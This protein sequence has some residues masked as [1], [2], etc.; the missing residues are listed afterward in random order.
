VKVEE[1]EVG[2]TYQSKGRDKTT[3][4]VTA[5]EDHN[6]ASLLPEIDG[7]DFLTYQLVRFQRDDG[8]LDEQLM[9]YFA[10]WAG[11][12]VVEGSK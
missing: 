12:V 11:S 9:D 5:V 2:K 4:R 8:S 6:L 1:I 7:I 10:R 3:R